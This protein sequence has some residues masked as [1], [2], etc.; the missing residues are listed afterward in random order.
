M[1][2]TEPTVVET[3]SGGTQHVWPLP[4]DEKTLAAV[5]SGLGKR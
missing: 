3:P 2:V 1:T 5:L 4:V